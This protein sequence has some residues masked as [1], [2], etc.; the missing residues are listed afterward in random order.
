MRACAPRSG[1]LR[2]LVP[3]LLITAA[4]LAPDGLGAWAQTSKYLKYEC[5]PSSRECS[6]RMLGIRGFAARLSP[7]RSLRLK[8]A[9]AI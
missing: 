2:A 4:L 1:A 5:N 9:P 3:S 7:A 6:R 8:R